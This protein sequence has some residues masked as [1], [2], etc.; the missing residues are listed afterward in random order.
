MKDK[1]IEYFVEKG[2][3]I[4]IGKHKDYG[5]YYDLNTQMKSHAHMVFKENCV[6]IYKRY[7]DFSTIVTKIDDTECYF[8]NVVDEICWEVK[9]CLHGRDFMNCAWEK[10]LVD[11]GYLKKHIETKASYS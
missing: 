5:I 7:G 4:T 1:I 10:V 11:G 9:D 6:H 3:E 2:I 8:D